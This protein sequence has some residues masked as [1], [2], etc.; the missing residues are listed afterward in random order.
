MRASRLLIGVG[1]HS[2]LPISRVLRL[3]QLDSLDDARALLGAEEYL[4]AAPLV[5]LRVKR[6]LR[7]SAVYTN[8]ES[9]LTQGERFSASPRGRS[10]P[11]FWMPWFRL[12]D[13][14][15]QAAVLVGLDDPGPVLVL[16]DCLFGRGISSLDHGAV[17]LW[18]SHSS[19]PIRS[20]SHPCST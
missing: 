19:S 16:H 9:S 10:A 15:V 18:N 14:D 8:G 1:S 7:F 5:A 4:R 3:R 20:V 2:T 12:P 13:E 17:R 6:V 11:A